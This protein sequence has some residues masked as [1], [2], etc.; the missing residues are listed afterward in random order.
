[1]A[2]DDQVYECCRNDNINMMINLINNNSNKYFDKT[3]SF[4]VACKYGSFQVVKYLI[5]K[6]KTGI[7]MRN[8][9]NNAFIKRVLFGEFKMRPSS[10]S[11]RMVSSCQIRK[12]SSALAKSTPLTK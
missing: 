7:L 10:A 5:N 4:E 12:M 3:Y 6:I 8:Y 2:F 9:S 11:V 1:M